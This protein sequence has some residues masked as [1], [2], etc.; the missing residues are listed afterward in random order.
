M[1]R[2]IILA[3]LISIAVAIIICYFAETNRM[4]LLLGVYPAIAFIA[5]GFVAWS[6]K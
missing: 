3:T 6:E 4:V 1:K 2:L 5:L